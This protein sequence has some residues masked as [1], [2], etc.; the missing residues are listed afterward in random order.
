MRSRFGV[1]GGKRGDKTSIS[2]SVLYPAAL[3]AASN[4]IKVEVAAK[5]GVSSFAK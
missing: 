4:I 2:L 1:L 3:S 5:F